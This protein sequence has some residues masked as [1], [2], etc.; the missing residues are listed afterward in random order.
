MGLFVTVTFTGDI[1]RYLGQGNLTHALLAL[2]LI[3]AS[4][5]Q[6]P[7]GLAG[8]GG[9]FAPTPFPVLERNGKR[10]TVKRGILDV[11]SPERLL[12][13]RVPRQVTMI[14][15]HNRVVF[16]IAGGVFNQVAKVEVEVFARIP[17]VPGPLTIASWR[18]LLN[19]KPIHLVSLN[20]NPSEPT[21]D[22]LT[23]LRMELSDVLFGGLDPELRVAE[24][25][26]ANL[27]AVIAGYPTIGRDVV[28][29]LGPAHG[30]KGELRDEFSHT[31]ASIQHLKGEIASAGR[32]AG[33]VSARIKG[34]G[35]P[36]GATT[37]TPAPPPPAPPVGVVQTDPG[38]SENMAPQAS[39]AFSTVRP[40]GVPVIEVND[41]T[42]YQQ[43]SGI[44]AAMTDTSAW[45][46]YDELSSSDRLALLQE[47]FG[48]SGIHLNFLRVPMAASDFT[49]SPDPYSYDD[50]P[51][52]QTDPSLSHFSI[53]HDLD[54]IIPVLQQALTVNPGLQILANPWSPPG[55]M[56]SNDSLDNVN[57]QGTLLLSAY[58]P[59]A[60]YFVKVIQTYEANGVPIDAI[61]PQ[62]EPR[63]SGAGT[64]YPGLTLPAA[65]EAIFISQYLQPALA[66]A[67][68][69]PKIYG[70]DLSWD[71]LTYADSLAASPV[72]GDLSGIAWHCYF[73]SPTVMS[74]LHQIASGLDQIA[75]ECSPEIR[76]F[77]APEYLISALR[78]WA[79]AVAVWNVA[80]DPQGGP[81]G[82]ANG[83]PG[84]TGVVSIDEQSHTVSLSSEYYEL[85]QV[86]EFVQPGA[87]R[88]D[89]PNFV[90]YSLN[91]SDIETIS[92]GL[93]DVAFQNPDGSKVLVAYNNSA[94][95]ISFAVESEGN[96]F[97]YTIPAQAMTTFTWR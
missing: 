14:R 65:D 44:G 90:T 20:V 40:E 49:V 5:A 70:N 88:I 83:C 94:A 19:R 7:A 2:V 57:D 45:L 82:T 1:E 22:Q 48:S 43:I 41:Q 87:A 36:P 6:A 39:L 17:T 71:Q 69:H 58:A 92:S 51:V 81:K 54:Y 46:I 53:A 33:Q 68:L 76:S 79:S 84:C 66:Q 31:A 10:V 12:P 91:S 23:A 30:G 24:H 62:N 73:G 26:D 96:Y 28:R 59:L 50:M 55:W 60:S 61:T 77:G 67:G 27:R 21:C 4:R 52:G 95:A 15:S 29:V 32:L 93:D 64:S 18:K 97:T 74:Q 42:R 72:A 3:P 80:L 8:E 86:S 38:L 35:P 16:Y 63:T 56:K 47:L 34:C 78:N 25:A 11:F 13:V 85:G 75:D 37:P 89:S 9:G